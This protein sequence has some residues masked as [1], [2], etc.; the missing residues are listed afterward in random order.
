MISGGFGLSTWWI[1]AVD[2]WAVMDLGFQQ[3]FGVVGKFWRSVPAIWVV[4]D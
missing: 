4:D 2:D 3:Q 1:W